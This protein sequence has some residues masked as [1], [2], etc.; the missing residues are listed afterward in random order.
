MASDRFDGAAVTLLSAGDYY[1]TLPALLSK[2]TRT[3]CVCMFHIALPAPDHPTRKLLRRLVAAQKRGVSVRVLLD[4]D[5]KRDPYL[6]RVINEAAVDY[7]GD[8]NVQCRYDKPSKLLH[9]KFITIDRNVTVIGSHNWSAGSY[10]RYGDVS[11]AI[12]SGTY[13]EHMNRRFRT[14]WSRAKGITQ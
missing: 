2:A 13:T 10:F 12:E 9:S 8:R 5:R 6:S 11:V 7:L 1:K 4:Y 14:M 3:I